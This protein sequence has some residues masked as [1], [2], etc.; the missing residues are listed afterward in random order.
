MLVPDSSSII[1]IEVWETICKSPA[2][3]QSAWHAQSIVYSPSLLR[4]P[5]NARDFFRQISL[6]KDVPKCNDSV[7]LVHIVLH[8]MSQSTPGVLGVLAGE[9]MPSPGLS[10][11]VEHAN[12]P[13][14]PLDYRLGK[15]TSR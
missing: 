5:R 13:Y 3:R 7:C 2:K 15:P 12:T 8:E 4:I 9:E 14:M 11:T 1:Y 6:Q 10:G